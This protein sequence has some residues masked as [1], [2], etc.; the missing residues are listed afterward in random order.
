MASIMEAF[1]A[2]TTAFPAS[3]Q[4]TIATAQTGVL[5]KLLENVSVFNVFLTLFAA[6]VIYDQSAWGSIEYRL[7][8]S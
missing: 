1:N 7:K 2:S 5:S 8:H 3:I 4:A 6:A